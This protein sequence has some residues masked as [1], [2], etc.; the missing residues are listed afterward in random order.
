MPISTTCP[1]CGKVIAG[2]DSAAG[3]KARCP[4]CKGVVEFPRAAE[5][6]PAAALA[7]A[8]AA[9]AQPESAGAAMAQAVAEEES[10]SRGAAHAESSPTPTPSRSGS[11]SSRS[12]STTVDRMLARTSPYDSLRLMA[13][14][15]FGVG[16]AVSVLVLLGGL[17]GLIVLSTAGSPWAGVGTFVGSL[18]LAVVLLLGARTVNELLRLWADVG[19]R[20]RHMTQMFEDSLNRPR[21]N[22]SV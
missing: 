3:H 18:V 19:D 4:L 22:G 17:G 9:K 21:E 10:G 15:I 14:I 8:M 12:A 5:A 7:A 11:R 2:P 16:I 13:A 1:G 6:N 20:A